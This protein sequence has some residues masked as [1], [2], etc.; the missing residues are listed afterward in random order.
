MSPQLETIC[1]RL[2][3]TLLWLDANTL[4]TVGELE[5]KC[6]ELKIASAAIFQDGAGG[7][8]PR[9]MRMQL[10]RSLTERRTFR[11][12]RFTLFVGQSMYEQNFS[13]S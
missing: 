7:K 9:V 2:D 13:T 1:E 3:K 6:N 11:R 4:A 5:Q 8:C 12:F 10:S